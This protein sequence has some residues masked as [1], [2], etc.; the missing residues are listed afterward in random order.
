MVFF[1]ENKNMSK[2]EKCS[3][4]QKGRIVIHKG[5][6]E[7]RI[8]PN[9]LEMYQQDGWEKGT[10][11]KH[12]KNNGKAHKGM[13]PANK[14]V[15]CSQEK[16]EKISNS[17]KGRNEHI[18]WNRDDDETKEKIKQMMEK[19]KHT[20]VERYGNAYG[21]DNNM[22]E[23]HKRKIGLNTTKKLTGYKFPDDERE[24]KTKKTY[25]TKK[26][27]NSFNTSTPEEQYYK[28]LKEQYKGKTI[29]RQYKDKERYPFYCDFYIVEDDL[30][31]EINAHWSHGGHPFDPNNRD[32][33]NIL[34]E[35]KEKAKVSQFYKNA[36]ET[37][38]VRDVKKQECARKNKLNYKVIY[39][40]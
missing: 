11:N 40:F 30:F 13:T 22:T 16:K 36:I 27:N 5:D 19:S 24:I 9:E 28:Q 35:W 32:D 34:N 18:W 7:K 6:C 12:R 20:K 21:K 33:L 25:E 26:K 15:P 10:S 31:I 23:E 38:T 2:E 3:T 8:Y 39:E 14:G 37:W 1:M 17:L 29:Y 4:T